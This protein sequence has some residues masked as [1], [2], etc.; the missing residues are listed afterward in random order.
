MSIVVEDGTG[1]AGAEAYHTRDFFD[2]FVISWGLGDPSNYDDYEEYEP[3]ARRGALVFDTVYGVR[4]GGYPLSGSQGLRFPMTGLVDV[5]SYAVANLPVQVQ[6]AAA[7]LT[8][9]EMTS[10]MSLLPTVTPGRV[11][12]AVSAGP[13]SVE[14]ESTAGGAGYVSG[15][16]PIMAIVEGLLAA[17]GGY[18]NSG[19]ARFGSAVRG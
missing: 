17:L 15:V 4:F 19:P 14:Y 8:W 9:Y 11:K 2:D 1:V 5:R 7:A 10:P 12:K 6:R 16:R 18:G 13:V 3:A